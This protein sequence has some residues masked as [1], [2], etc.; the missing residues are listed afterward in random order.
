[1]NSNGKRIFPLDK[2]KTNSK[3]ELSN[4]NNKAKLINLI[5][6]K[7][8]ISLL[9]NLKYNNMSLSHK[10]NVT[11]KGYLCKNPSLQKS[12]ASLENNFNNIKKM[13]L[14]DFSNYKNI[15][16][17]KKIKKDVDTS[18][19]NLKLRLKNKS[20]ILKNK[21][22]YEIP[23]DN[24]SY[25][26]KKKCLIKNQKSESI[27]KLKLKKSQSIS[28]SRNLN[29][30]GYSF[31]GKKIF[32]KSLSQHKIN[33]SINGNIQSSKYLNSKIKNISQDLKH[34]I[35]LF[36]NEQ[37]LKKSKSKKVI[38]S[39]EKNN[40]CG[41]ITTNNSDKENTDFSTKKN[42]LTTHSNNMPYITTN[43]NNSTNI[44]ETNNNE[45]ISENKLLKQKKIIKKKLG[46]PF[47]PNSK[48]LE[49]F[50]QLESSKNNLVIRNNKSQINIPFNKKNN[51]KY[52]IKRNN[53]PFDNRRI[54]IGKCIIHH[55]ARNK[56]NTKDSYFDLYT[57]TNNEEHNAR[58]N[59]FIESF[60]SFKGNNISCVLKNN[61]LNVYRNENIVKEDSIG[62]EM[63][64]FR[65]VATIQENKK[66]IKC[67]DK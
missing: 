43:F 24:I 11:K 53:S 12:K 17:R 40:I 28:I 15:K 65:I 4:N 23:N 57:N 25:I 41:N 50:N 30:S 8:P 1:M 31:E 36:I 60:D 44:T 34:K 49:Y 42:N 35:N 7:K 29:M 38:K 64:H 19:N 14:Q 37:K 66:L 39:L 21:F 20:F 6:S 22:S 47:H 13:Q 48:K 56:K 62:V 54:K 55:S 26:K 46:L 5:L 58:N 32:N 67:E 61:N 51:K 9:S 33:C 63:A 2:N 10:I 59:Y 45:L 52:E 18:C 16:K 27:T 3:K